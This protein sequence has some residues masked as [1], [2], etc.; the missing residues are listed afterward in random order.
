[1]CIE[2][3]THIFNVLSIPNFDGM[4]FSGHL[5]HYPLI[6]FEICGFNLGIFYTNICDI[7]VL[8]NIE[9]MFDLFL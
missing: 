1:M 2:W 5:N 9:S 6:Y 4:P 7:S 8:Q 3:H